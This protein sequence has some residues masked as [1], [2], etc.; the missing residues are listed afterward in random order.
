MATLKVDT[1]TAT[2]ITRAARKEAGY[3]I[4]GLSHRQVKDVVRQLLEKSEPTIEE[5]VVLELAAARLAQSTHIQRK[6][7][8]AKQN[9]LPVSVD[10]N[11]YVGGYLAPIRSKVG[12]VVEKIVQTGKEPASHP[13]GGWLSAP[14]DTT[15]G[16]GESRRLEGEQHNTHEVDSLK[17]QRDEAQRNLEVTR[18]QLEGAERQLE[19]SQQTVQK[20]QRELAHLRKAPITAHMRITREHKPDEI[21]EITDGRRLHFYAEPDQL[22]QLDEAKLLKEQNQSLRASLTEMTQ[23][24]VEF[25]RLY[26]EVQADAARLEAENLTASE[27]AISARVS[28]LQ[29]ENER[30]RTALKESLDREEKYD[31]AEEANLREM[32]ESA[33]ALKQR[34]QKAEAAQA[35]LQAMLNAK[36]EEQKTAQAAAKERVKAA[37]ERAE[38]AAAERQEQLATQAA[39]HKA[40]QAAAERRA[41]AA[42]ELLNGI[43]AS[44][45]AVSSAKGQPADMQAAIIRQQQEL[46]KAATKS[47]QERDGVARQLEEAQTELERALASNVEIAQNFAQQLAEKDAELAEAQRDRGSEA[48]TGRSPIAPSPFSTVDSGLGDSVVGQ[49]EM[50]IETLKQKNQKLA[51]ENQALSEQVES[52]KSQITDET[53]LFRP[54]VTLDQKRPASAPPIV[55]YE[56]DMLW[57]VIERQQSTADEL[58]ADLE[59]EKRLNAPATDSELTSLRSIAAKHAAL[60]ERL[61]SAE[62]KPQHRLMSRYITLENK[63]EQVIQESAAEIQDLQEA[64]QRVVERQKEAEKANADQLARLER[65]VTKKESFGQIAKQY[66]NAIHGTL[67][68]SNTETAPTNIREK[69]APKFAQALLETVFADKQKELEEREAAIKE[70]EAQQDFERTERAVR[71]GGTRIPAP[72]VGDWTARAKPRTDEAAEIMGAVK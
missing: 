41:A 27:N 17:E 54:L 67:R 28:K 63:L 72:V 5:Q 68:R 20:Q 13:M 70:R 60:C 21:I 66:Q 55:G 4:E 15:G 59:Q 8:K 29:D 30:L 46:V 62:A 2:Q 31:E 1:K 34:A 19:K 23:T 48:V 61:L 36:E 42:E 14:L 47:A 3:A 58:R 40:A 65:E 18:R 33:E 50:A 51:E 56:K 9:N 16:R 38:A 37:E 53:Q 52:L 11:Q 35:D 57:K 24:A 44:V 64:H 12:G 45:G 26:K 43:M 49:T 71:G 22:K 32:Q 10:Y 6:T 25:K 7:Q 39:E 69:F